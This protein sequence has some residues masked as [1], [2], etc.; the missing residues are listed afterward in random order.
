M[1]QSLMSFQVAET[2]KRLRDALIRRRRK[3]MDAAFRG[4]R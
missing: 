4:H 3:V 1:N 2:M